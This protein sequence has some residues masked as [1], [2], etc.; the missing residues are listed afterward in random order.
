MTTYQ[1]N[2][3]ILRNKERAQEL[4]D[5]DIAAIYLGYLDYRELEVELRQQHYVY[6]ESC[7]GDHGTMKYMGVDIIRTAKPRHIHA[8]FNLPEL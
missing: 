5:M 1:L 6:D 3:L 4:F 2:Q 7:K 8:A